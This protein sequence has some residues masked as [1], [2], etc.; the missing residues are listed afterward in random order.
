MKNPNQTNA[1]PTTNNAT[2]P[3]NKTTKKHTYRID[4][5]HRPGLLL[6][7]AQLSRLVV[8]L[9][10]VAADCFNP[11]PDYQCIS[12]RREVL[13]RNAI[14]IARRPD[15]RAA[16][17]CS[18][19]LIDV[20]GVGEVLHLG[21][22]C[23]S[24][25]D[26]G[27]G[28]THLLT[29]KLLTQYLLRRPFERV[30]FSNVACVLSSLGNVALHFDDVFPSP[31]YRG[32]PSAKHAAIAATID[33]KHRADIYIDADAQLDNATFVFRGSNV[34]GNVFHKEREDG[35]YHH[36]EDALNAFYG[37]IMRW[38]AGDEVLQ[39][40][41]ISLRRLLKHGLRTAVIPRKPRRRLV[42]FKKAARAA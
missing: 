31:F 10:G 17:F 33:R 29:T 9:R 20:E 34:P 2:E 1:T 16:G 27:A 6:D 38:E 3:K 5:L 25:D 36:R 12:G 22:T 14:A 18:A 15:G 37:G 35:R 4:Y 39:I 24:L 26:R 41:H 28:L 40:G 42:A 8:D 32:V 11:L 21:L 7:D 23:V 19:L 13:S 30:W